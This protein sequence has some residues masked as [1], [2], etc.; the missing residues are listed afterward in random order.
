VDEVAGYGLKKSLS[1]PKACIGNPVTLKSLGGPLNK[2]AINT[3]QNQYLIYISG[4][5]AF[6]NH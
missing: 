1:F 3:M 4:M 5:Y 6:I 2:K